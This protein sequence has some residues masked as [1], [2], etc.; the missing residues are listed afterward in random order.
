MLKTE[1]DRSSPC[2]EMPEEQIDETLAESFPASD[3]PSWT[4]GIDTPCADTRGESADKSLN[5]LTPNSKLPD[6]SIPRKSGD[7]R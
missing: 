6:Q 2:E 1:P 5:P 3:P 4:L 7:S